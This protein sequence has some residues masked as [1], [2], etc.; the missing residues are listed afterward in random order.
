MLCDSASA[1]E[2]YPV[3]FSNMPRPASVIFS[4]VLASTLWPDFLAAMPKAVKEFVSGWSNFRHATWRWQIA[5][6]RTEAG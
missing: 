1:V 6:E 2:A 5:A 3:S 4:A